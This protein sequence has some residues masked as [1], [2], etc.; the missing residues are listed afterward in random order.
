MMIVRNV[1][2]DSMKYSFGKATLEWA[3][4]YLVSKTLLEI[5]YPSILIT[6]SNYLV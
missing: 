5:E 6:Q 3:E 2:G 1:I 4:F